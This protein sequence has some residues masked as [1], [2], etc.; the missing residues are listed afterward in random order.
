MTNIGG[1]INLKN[2]FLSCFNFFTLS[3]VSRLQQ[4]G[5]RLNKL[6]NDL[7]RTYRNIYNRGERYFKIK[8]ELEGKMLI[9]HD[10]FK[11]Q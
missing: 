10:K 4:N 9:N 1:N 5:E 3:L 2:T 6:M 7:E 8:L 11:K